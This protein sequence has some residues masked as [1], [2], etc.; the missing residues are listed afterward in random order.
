MSS[1][2]GLREKLMEGLK[3]QFSVAWGDL[4]SAISFRNIETNPVDIR[5]F[6]DLSLAVQHSREVVFDYCKLGTKSFET[7]N[8]LQAIPPDLHQLPMVCSRHDTLRK[9]VRRFVL[10]RMQSLRMLDTTFSRPKNFSADK[11]LKGSFGV[12]SGDKPIEIRIWFSSFAARLVGER[13][14]HH[15][16]KSQLANDEIELRLTLTSLV[17]V[18][19]WILSWGSRKGT[20][21]S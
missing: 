6:K 9:E 20:R 17:E 12:F 10:G 15:S 8:L 19:Q 1:R 4:D 2:F 13:Q 11:C 14:W 21:P 3:G 16:Q 18:S 7:R 5:I